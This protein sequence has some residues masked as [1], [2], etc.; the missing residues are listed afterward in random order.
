MFGGEVLL[1]LLLLGLAGVVLAALALPLVPARR[2][3]LQ[4]FPAVTVGL[5]VLNTYLFLIT[6]H[7][8]QLSEE[9]ARGWGLTPQSATLITLLTSAFLHG[10]WL[11]LGGN[12]V[13]LALF[14]P[15]VEEALGRIEYLLFYIGCGI[16]AGLLHVIVSATLLPG[17]ADVPMIGASGAIFGVLGLFAVRFYRARVRVLLFAHVP[18][19]WAVGCFAALQVIAGVASLA[20]GGRSDSTANWAHVGGFLFGMLLALPLKM[21]EDGRRE[22]QKED[23]EDAASAGRMDQAAAYYRLLLTDKPDD[24][25]AHR[26]LGRVCVQL[27]QGEAAHRHF[28]DALR[29]SLRAG[30]SP[31]VAD[32][33]EEVC[34]S[35]T[36]FPLPP[37]LLQRVGSAC[38]EMQRF[39]LALRALGDLCRDFPQ[40]PE[41]EM[42]LLRMG[43][44]HLQRLG[45]PDSAQGI[46]EEFLRLYPA[47]EWRTHVQRLLGEARQ[48]QHPGGPLPA[49]GA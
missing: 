16:A 2:R 28:T 36:A 20:D 34:L 18:A 11:H 37:S 6:S 24:V 17:A 13:G 46:L 38:E 49:P 9:I 31:A 41:A 26:A 4:T 30:H 7:G 29:L 5:I 19:I 15:H 42:A 35:F 40:A 43:K 8:G 48:A 14:G 45:Q 21:R 39:P 22:Y 33:Y 27:G 25:E 10:S 23:A 1:L 32:V 44:L 3:A 12:M 47:S